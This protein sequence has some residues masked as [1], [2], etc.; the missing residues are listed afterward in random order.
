MS[1]SS[2]KDDQLNPFQE[3]EDQS[4]RQFWNSRSSESI[5][6]GL[7]SKM[8]TFRF[9]GRTA[10]LYSTPFATIAS[11][12]SRSVGKVLSTFLLS[13]DFSITALSTAGTRSRSVYQNDVQAVL[14][15]AILQLTFRIRYTDDVHRI[16][17]QLLEEIYR[18]LGLVGRYDILLIEAGSVKVTLELPEEEAILFLNAFNSGRLSDLG[19]ENIRMLE[20]KVKD[21]TPLFSKLDVARLKEWIAKGAVKDAFDY[22]VKALDSTHRLYDHFVQLSNRY[23]KLINEQR[24]SDTERQ[25]IGINQLVLQLLR[26]LN[27]LEKSFG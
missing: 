21:T 25:Q 17:A 4:S 14:R 7:E 19:M 16:V 6:Q 26:K 23:Y 1:S 9:I 3:L 24:S 18:R 27:E 11:E 8:D 15:S 5:W 12:L 20:Y 13:V 2:S 10:E 22:V